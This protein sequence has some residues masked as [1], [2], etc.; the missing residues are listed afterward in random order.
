MSKYIPEIS[1]DNLEGLSLSLKLLLGFLFRKY[2]LIPQ[3]VCDP[4]GFLQEFTY[5][6]I[7]GFLQ[8]LSW[9]LIRISLGFITGFPPRV[10]LWLFQEFIL[11]NLQD[12]SSENF[13][14][15]FRNP[16]EVLSGNPTGAQTL[17]L[18]VLFFSFICESS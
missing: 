1:L 4:L 8:E 14:A 16:P 15:V 6:I 5:D 9:I 7:L 11:G 12:F 18:S 17:R 2:V 13:P 3:K 10:L